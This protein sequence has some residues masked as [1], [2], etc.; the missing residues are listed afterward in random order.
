MAPLER[1]SNAS[2]MCSCC[3]QHSPGFYELTSMYILW[4]QCYDPT[5]LLSFFQNVYTKPT[6]L[7]WLRVVT[8]RFLGVLS[9]SSFTSQIE[10]GSTL[11]WFSDSQ[12]IHSRQWF[13]HQIYQPWQGFEPVPDGCANHYVVANRWRRKHYKL[14]T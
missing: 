6:F 1:S 3:F 7:R 2:S 8:D 5:E 13:L 9:G 14:I 12:G 11:V 4:L 10:T